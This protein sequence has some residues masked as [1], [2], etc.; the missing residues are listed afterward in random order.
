VRPWRRPWYYAEV[1]EPYS[2]IIGI[3]AVLVAMTGVQA[4]RLSTYTSV[5]S[6]VVGGVVIGMVVHELMHRNVARRYGMRS[7]YVINWLGVIVT[8]VTAILPIKLIAPGYTRVYS[9]GFEE[10]RK[11]ILYSVAAG[12]TSNIV[13]ALAALIAGVLA[14]ALASSAFAATFTSTWLIGFSNINSYLAFFNLLPI[15]PLD[16]YKIFRLSLELWIIMF[17]ASIAFFAATLMLL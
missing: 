9:R 6:Y 11:G 14:R 17:I 5:Y 13:M 3:L 2:W 12:P 16:G 4:F 7:S 15:P 8:L 10:D 1:D